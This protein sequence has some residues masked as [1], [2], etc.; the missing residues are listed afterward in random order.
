[1]LGM[2]GPVTW[3]GFWMGRGMAMG[4]GLVG[5]GIR[6]LENGNLIQGVGWVPAGILMARGIKAILY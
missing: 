2:M 4:S 5:M 1:M 3:A 6:I